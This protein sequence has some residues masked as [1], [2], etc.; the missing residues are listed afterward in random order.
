MDR[1]IVD[2]TIMITTII[3]TDITMAI[4]TDIITDIMEDITTD[5][6][7]D[8]MEDTTEEGI[9]EVGI[10]E[11][12]I[13]IKPLITYLYVLLMKLDNNKKLTLSEPFVHFHDD[14][15][16]SSSFLQA[17]QNTFIILS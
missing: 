16:E 3:T 9:T 2:T 14:F 4:T 7:E 11:A 13:E 5:I 8:I 17:H 15:F 6:M 10:M 12:I 1:I